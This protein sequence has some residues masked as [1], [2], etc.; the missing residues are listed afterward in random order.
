ML[1]SSSPVRA[2]WPRWLVP[3]CISKPSSVV[4]L[5]SKLIGANDTHPSCGVAVSVQLAPAWVAISLGMDNR[6]LGPVAG[7]V[8]PARRPS[9]RALLRWAV[10]G[11]FPWLLLAAGQ[12]AW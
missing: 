4:H 9:R 5:P 12:L 2:K 10:G 7:M 8:D 11:I 6:T 3:N 1:S